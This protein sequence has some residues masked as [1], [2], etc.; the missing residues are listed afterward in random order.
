MT[1]PSITKAAGHG[2]TRWRVTLIAALLFVLVAAVF[3]PS[4]R[5][6]FIPYDDPKYVTQN[7]HVNT[8][9]TW[10]NLRWALTST[11]A[12]NWHPLTWMSHMLDCQLFGLN[13]AGHHLTNLLL[14]A[15]STMLLFVALRRMTR[16]DWPSLVVAALFGLH[17]MHVESVAWISER[18]DVLSTAFA[19]GVLWLYAVR[20][21]WLREK[22]RGTA[23][24]Y[25][26]TWLCFALGLAAKSMLVTLPCVL[27]LL[28][29]WPLRRW[30]DST[31]R[32]RWWL[33][34][35]KLPF[36][37]C[38]AGVS[39]ITVLA[40]SE[41][42]AVGSV[43]D[44]TLPVRVGTALISYC[45]YLGHCVYPAHLGVFYPN[46]AQQPPWPQEVG[47]VAVLAAI[48]LGAIAFARRR[49]YLLIGWLWFLGTLVPVIGFVQVGGQ[50]MADR[51]SYFPLVGVFV[52]LAWGLAEAP[53]A[54]ARHRLAWG[55]AGVA[56]L[57]ALATLTTRQLRFW[58]SGETLFR[59]T[60]A[61]TQD[62]WVA[63]FNL[64]I[65]LRA[66]AP[67]E[68]REHLD[69]TL[70]ILANFAARYE[71]KGINLAQTPGRA[72]EAEK[73]LRTAIRVMKSLPGPHY[74]LGVLLA[75]TPERRDEAIAELRTATQL[76]PD[77]VEAQL[78]LAGL[79]SSQPDRTDESIAAYAAVLAARP[80]D[81]DAHY[82]LGLALARVPWRRGEALDHLEAAV[83]LRPDSA[84]ARAA[85]ARL[86]SELGLR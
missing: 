3:L 82:H 49:P 35:E 38:S 86:R 64:F 78:A 56:A 85:V 54:W 66:S 55:I 76:K 25:A 83:K 22:R 4:I 27:L 58:R 16:A 68:A 17:P 20:A 36:L 7:V 59:H 73:S 6:G 75:R 33:V 43:D 14:H 12:S 26:A 28:D 23:W 60:A 63:H 46:F 8:G 1:A 47:A 84:P 80:A 11:E 13:A 2:S 44:F 61:I 79:L 37:A 41:G 32:G 45:R 21:D 42:E 51:Y 57:A 72:Q 69:Q 18:K 81:F 9:L 31:T 24:L 39:L 71:T 74:H 40:Q 62:N 15:F 5:Q 77:F 52:M 70:R 48:T 10:A 67:Q 50:T 65:V 19:T 29:F 34:A 30:P 53:L